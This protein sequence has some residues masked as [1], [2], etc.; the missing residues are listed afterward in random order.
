MSRLLG[1]SK[2]QRH[3][4]T[5]RDQQPDLDIFHGQTSKGNEQNVMTAQV[6]TG[7][8]R[9]TEAPDI[10]PRPKTANAASSPSWNVAT[11]GPPIVIT[12]DNEVFCFPTPT[13]RRTN[14]SPAAAPPPSSPASGMLFKPD[15][16]GIGVAI[17]SP[18]QIQHFPSP[19][20]QGLRRQA[21]NDIFNPTKSTDC[22]NEPREPRHDMND[23]SRPKISRWRSLGGFFGRRDRNA[24]QQSD[25][26]SPRQPESKVDDSSTRSPANECAA[27]SDHPRE[28]PKRS[29]QAGKQRR[30]VEHSATLPKYPSTAPVDTPTSPQR[31]ML[32][33]N[34]P[35]VQLERYS[36][37]FSSVL[38]NRQSNLLARRQGD[39]GTTLKV[40]LAHHFQTP[41][42]PLA[43]LIN[44]RSKFPP[45]HPPPPSAAV[46]PPPP[47]QHPPPP[48]P[49]FPPRPPA[50]NRASTPPAPTPSS[51]VRGPSVAQKHRPAPSP[52]IP[53][54]P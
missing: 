3:K 53:S 31:P 1:R 13:P 35:D 41:L 19:L 39:K 54:I 33:I 10:H 47:A 48:T 8:G 22:S 9:W 15:D 6:A 29:K 32:D 24:V 16:I 37:M 45:P 52:L 51:R 43:N 49:S 20:S 34:I 40:R 36:V 7:A 44:S 2:S 38:P 14:F 25:Y 12:A 30:C 23:T 28:T 46:Q 27:Q 18:T 42:P 21:S 17:G 4:A 50:N 5:R 11:K 26:Q